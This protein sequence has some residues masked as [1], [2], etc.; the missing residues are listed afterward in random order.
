MVKQESELQWWERVKFGFGSA[1]NDVVTR[2]ASID[3]IAVQMEASGTCSQRTICLLG[4]FFSFV[5]P[6]LSLLIYQT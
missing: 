3:P 1:M 6:N 2:E 4:F 5:I